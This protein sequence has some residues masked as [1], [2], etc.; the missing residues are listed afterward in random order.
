MD[1]YEDG[2]E[3]ASCGLSITAGSPAMAHPHRRSS[4]PSILDILPQC[5]LL[6]IIAFSSTVHDCYSLSLVC[7][8]L[9][10]LCASN[11]V[12]RPFYTLRFHDDPQLIDSSEH[13]MSNSIMIQYR[14]RINDPFVGDK[15]QVCFS[16]LELLKNE[17][18][19]FFECF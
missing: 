5:I 6:D 11:I 8:Q 3:N 18:Y 1:D 13:L 2:Q 9:R 10:E 15:L 17:L 14:D 7:K 4:Q 19:S 16:C 12:W